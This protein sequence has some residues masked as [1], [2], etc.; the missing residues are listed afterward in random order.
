MCAETPWWRC[1]RKL[2]AELLVARGY[3]VVH[4]MGPRDARAH[5]LSE[6]AEVRGG[7][8][9]LCGAVVA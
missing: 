5:R 7:T 9:Y 2:I 4:L 8:L 6:D 1:H 3:E